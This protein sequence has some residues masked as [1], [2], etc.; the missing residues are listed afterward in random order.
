MWSIPRKV[1]EFSDSPPPNRG[2]LLLQKYNIFLKTIRA[3]ILKYRSIP[4]K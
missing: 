3:F 1:V 4:T 2:A